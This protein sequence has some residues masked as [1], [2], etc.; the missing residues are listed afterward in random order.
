MLALP[1][2]SLLSVP[3]T[4]WASDEVVDAQIDRAKSRET[5]KPLRSVAV[6]KWFSNARPVKSRLWRKWPACSARALM[7]S[8]LG[9]HQ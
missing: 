8:A 6:P 1:L 9:P 5:R 2:Q 4:R 7:I 3:I